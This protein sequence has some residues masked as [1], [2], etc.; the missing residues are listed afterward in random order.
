MKKKLS[1]ILACAMLTTSLAACGSTAPKTETAKP[2]AAKT[3]TAQA[4]PAE[5]TKDDPFNVQVTDDMKNKAKDF[6]VGFVTDMGGIDDKSFNQGTWEG[7]KKFEEM[8]GSKTNYSPSK[9]DA[10]YIPNLSTFAEDGYDLVVA[11]GFLFKDSIAKVAD[12]FPDT[13]FLLIDDVVEGKKNVASATFAAEQ[14]SYLV[15]VAAG[16]TAKKAGKNAVGFLGGGDFPLIQAFEAGFE[17]G[18]ASVDPKIKVLVEYVGDFADSGKAQSKASKMYDEGAYVIFHAAGAAGNGLIKEAKDRKMN[19]K[20]AWVIGVD[21]DQYADGIYKDNKS[22]ML[23]SMVKRVD[24]AAFDIAMK[25]LQ[26]QFP[27]GKPMLFDISN[28]GIGIPKEN[29]NLT[30][31]VKTKV[32]EAEQKVKSGEIKVTVNPKRLEKK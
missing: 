30:D 22:V 25:S 11:A 15:G 29:P 9:S 19:D 18:V 1:L 2:E 6:T 7:V 17:Q 10:D 16:E 14:G 13:K 23:T 27:G 4:K 24:V 26:D 28:G 32:A 31:E 12:N 20:D 8:T 3:E 5:A 21:R